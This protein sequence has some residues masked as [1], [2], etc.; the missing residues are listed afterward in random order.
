VKTE[1]DPL[2]PEPPAAMRGTLDAIRRLERLVTAAPLEG[3][4]LRYG[5]F[6]GPRASDELVELVRR[7]KLPLVGD[8]AGVWS[9]GH[10]EDAAAA[11]V[12]AVESRVTGVCN[13]VDDEP[14]PVSEWL[15]YLAQFLGAKP[16]RRVP[17]WL[18]RLAAGEAVVSMMTEI[19]GASNAKAKRE[20]DWR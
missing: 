14:A 16:P 10:V 12:S 4:V 1:E 11:T 9:W 2:D 20:L 17:V 8:G 15:P 6:Y 18:A 5:S 7:R 3:V 13:V 19:R